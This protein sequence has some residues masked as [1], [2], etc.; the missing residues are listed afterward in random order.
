MDGPKRVFLLA[1]GW[2]FIVLGIVGLVLPI[3]QGILFLIVG[4][5]I[6]APVSPLAAGLV[7][8]IRARAPKGWVERAEA[9][10]ERFVGSDDEDGAD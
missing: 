2:G 8:R 5:L 6:L 7:E 10:K 4:L 9:Q 3:L 1:V